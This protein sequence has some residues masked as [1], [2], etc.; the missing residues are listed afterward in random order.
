MTVP[1]MVPCVLAEQ[2]PAAPL[3]TPVAANAGI[4]QHAAALAADALALRDYAAK[5]AALLTACTKS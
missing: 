5:Q 3:P 4:Q 1:Q 2:V